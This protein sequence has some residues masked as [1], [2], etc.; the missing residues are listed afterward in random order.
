MAFSSAAARS[1][2]ARGYEFA[3]AGRGSECEDT[4]IC[5]A[6]D[7]VG[8]RGRSCDRAPMIRCGKLFRRKLSR[9]ATAVP[10]DAPVAAC[11]SAAQQA[12]GVFVPP[13]PVMHMRM[14]RDDYLLT[15]TFRLPPKIPLPEPV[16][17]YQYGSTYSGGRCEDPAARPSLITKQHRRLLGSAHGLTGYIFIYSNSQCAPICKD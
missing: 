17:R 6:A 8:A 10:G 14:T 12:A 9:R 2:L 7:A 11:R 13:R 16:L 3:S 15:T 1:R 4:G 5:G